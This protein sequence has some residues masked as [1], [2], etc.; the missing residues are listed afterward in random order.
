MSYKSNSERHHLQNIKGNMIRSQRLFPIRRL[1]SF[2]FLIRCLTSPSMENLQ[3]S[4]YRV[5]YRL[6]LPHN[7]VI[8]QPVF[9]HTFI[10]L[11][12]VIKWWSHLQRDRL[13]CYSMLI[14]RE[15]GEKSNW[16]S[17][18]SRFNLSIFSFSSFRLGVHLHR[19]SVAGIDPESVEQLSP[20]AKTF[21]GPQLSSKL[22]KG[23]PFPLKVL[24]LSC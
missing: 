19:A 5:S 21:I 22:Q 1:L 17:E 11:V 4:D 6:T 18:I 3:L 8:S 23:M 7:T 13:M 24:F 14:K 10:L 9:S 16:I 12:V 15:C 2:S 20:L